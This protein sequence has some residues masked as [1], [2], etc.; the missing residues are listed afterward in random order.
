MAPDASDVKR[1]LGSTDLTNSE[2]QAFID[3]A[4][5]EYEAVIGSEAVDA[6]LKDLVITRLA[7]HGVATGPE[8]QVDSAGEGDGNITFA[9]D[10]GEGLNATTHGQRAQDLDPSGQLGGGE[11]DESNDHFTLST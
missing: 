9:G 4:A 10:T 3:E 11:D 6:N 1:A 5:A 2:I 7:A 8:R